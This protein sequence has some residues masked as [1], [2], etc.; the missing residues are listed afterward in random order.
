MNDQLKPYTGHTLPGEGYA[1]GGARYTDDE[2]AV[3]NLGQW[4]CAICG[5]W[6]VQDENDICP[7]CLEKAEKSHYISG[8]ARVRAIR[9]IVERHQ[10]EFV[11]G[12][13]MD[14]FTAQ[15]ILSI[16]DNLG[17]ENQARY[18]D[19]AATRMAAIAWK[20]VEKLGG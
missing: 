2:L 11:D 4:P 3:I 18:K 7:K 20:L 13:L 5:E 1:D 8:D 6:A 12:A 9:R 17:P 19:M 10:W 16:F 14:A 15:T